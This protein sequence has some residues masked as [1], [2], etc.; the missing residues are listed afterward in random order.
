AATS[1]LVTGV[2]FMTITAAAFLTVPRLLAGMYTDHPAVIGLAA[3]LIPIAGVFQVFDGIQAV[4]SGI[5]RGIGDTRV[6][7]LVYLA[8]FWCVGVPVSAWLAFG[9]GYRATG[10]WWG[11]VAGLGAVAVFLM[12]RVRMRLSRS[13]GRI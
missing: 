12:I 13:I 10:L 5:L 7:L 4:G 2:G 11:F 8:G 1:G 3:S 6:A 9:A